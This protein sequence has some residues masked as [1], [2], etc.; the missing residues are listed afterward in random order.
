M[1]QARSVLNSYIPA[2]QW[3]MDYLN[4]NIT[5]PV[6]QGAQ[7][8]QTG[9]NGQPGQGVMSN[10]SMQS[11]GDSVA[12]ATPTG[13]E[14]H[15]MPLALGILG[16]G[17]AKFGSALANAQKGFN[18]PVHPDDVKELSPI[19]ERLLT[20]SDNPNYF[21]NQLPQDHKV[22]GPVAEHYLPGV[23]KALKNDPVQIA[24]AL[25]NRIIIDRKAIPN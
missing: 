12:N 7:D 17:S 8:F 9:F 21:I 22:L 13:A 23:T 19:I 20:H 11:L 16:K 2:T 18:I 4:N 3:A 10:N 6:Q 24:Q 15:A 25:L 1:D 5:R 14:A